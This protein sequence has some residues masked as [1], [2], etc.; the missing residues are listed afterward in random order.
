MNERGFTT[1]ELKGALHP[2]FGD[3]RRVRFQDV[4]AAGIIFYPRILEYMSDAYIAMMMS[5][6][7]DLP[8]ELHTG[9]VGT[10]LVHAEAD[11]LAPLRF[12]DEVSVEVVGVK[13]GE[14]SFTVGYRVRMANGKVAA[15][16]QTVHVCLDR[17]TFK[18]Q[19]IPEGL[20]GML[21]GE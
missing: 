9:T 12:G 10:P 4:D 20:R 21:V 17:A 14:T 19:A 16:G 2:R 6:G 18:P 7:W 13:V 15:V 8:R 1:A 5:A 3:A 11:Y